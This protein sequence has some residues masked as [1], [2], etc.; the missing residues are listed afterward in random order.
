MLFR[1]TARHRVRRGK[2]MMLFALLLPALLGVAGLVIDV[3]LLLAAYRQAQNAADAAALAAAMDCLQGKSTN[4]AAA[5]AAA[6]VSRQAG[7]AQATVQVNVPPT[8][9]PYA[10]NANYVEVIVSS[11]TGTFFIQVLGAATTSSVCA[12]AVAGYEA[13]AAPEAVRALDST[14]CPGLTVDGVQLTVN[15]QLAINSEGAGMDQQ[16]QGINLGSPP[17][18]VN[19]VNA[20]TLRAAQLRVV[21]GVNATS[22]FLNLSS[23]TTCLQAGCLPVPDPFLYLL[24]PTRNQGIVPSFPGYNGQ[25]YTSPQQ[26]AITVTNN[27]M[28]TLDPGVY[29]SIEITGTGAAAVTFNPGIYVLLGGNANGHALH[30]STAG[31]VTGN[32]VM[33]YNTGSNFGTASGAPDN[34]DGNVAGTDSDASVTFGSVL[35][36]AGSLTLSPISDTKSP[37]YG[38]LLYQRRWNRSTITLQTNDPGDT[39]AGTVYARWANVVL[40]GPGAYNGQFLVGSLTVNAQAG[41]TLNVNYGPMVARANQV[42][43]VE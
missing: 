26:V 18:G 27:D 1:D 10:G 7:L 33:F 12:R 34:S 37:F 8:Q 41:S 3:G 31:K 9:G 43:L 16:G 24:T 11:S 6:L 5:T 19:L 36:N 28:L 38:L 21:G 22:G 2:V 23:S 14:A 35:F 15:G 17:T 30:V 39:I 13:V 20:G 32:G 25:T 29:Q 42:F 40:T 4:T